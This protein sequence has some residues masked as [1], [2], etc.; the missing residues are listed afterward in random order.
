LALA[1]IALQDIGRAGRISQRDIGVRSQ[2]IEAVAGKSR[3]LVLRPPAKFMQRNVLSGAPCRE[4]GGSGSIDVNLPVYVGQ[5]RII[6]LTVARRPRQPIAA[7]DATCLSEAER[8]API[9][10]R[11]LCNRS[12]E[13]FARGFEFSDRGDQQR[14]NAR[15]HDIGDRPFGRGEAEC[16]IGRRD[17]PP[18]KADPLN[19]VAVEQP[20]WRSG[21]E[22]R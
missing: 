9:V 17:Q 3:R 18:G 13:I 14:R 20:V 6:I 2:Q 15:A 22:N 1:G 16:P 7:M 11:Q 8:A 19:L 21:A 12:K 4:L 10:Q 5:G